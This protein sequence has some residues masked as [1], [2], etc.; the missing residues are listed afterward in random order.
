MSCYSLAKQIKGE[1]DLEALETLLPK[2]LITIV[3]HYHLDIVSKMK[4][5][6][7]SEFCTVS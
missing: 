2:D 1:E 3:Y 4:S 6:K 7:N 5:K